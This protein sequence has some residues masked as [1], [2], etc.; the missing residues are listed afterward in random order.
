MKLN[1]NFITQDI[2]D[3][4]F[5]VPIGNENFHGIVKNNKSAAFI[6]NCLQD[7]TTEEEILEKMINHYNAPKEVLQ[8]GITTVLSKLRDIGALEE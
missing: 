1:P 8:K 4:Q 6:V 5:L 2:D 7:D 3:S